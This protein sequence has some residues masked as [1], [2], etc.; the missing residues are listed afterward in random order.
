MF[1][2][3]INRDKIAQYPLSSR[4]DSK[5]LVIRRSSGSIEHRMFKDILDYLEK[6]DLVI[7]NNTKVLK[8]R[9]YGVK[10]NGKRVEI[11]L[12]K[13]L[14]SDTWSVMTRGIRKGR[15]FFS[16][17]GSAEIYREDDKKLAKFYGKK[18]DELMEII[19]EIPLP[20]YIK[21]KSEEFDQRRYQTIYA[22][23]NGSIAAP[24]AGLHFDKELLNNMEQ[25]GI[26]VKYITLHV[27]PGTFRPIRTT[28]IE[29]HKMDEEDYEIYRDT[30]NTYREVRA[31]KGRVIAVGTTVTRTLESAFF[32]G[33]IRWGRGST[34]L[35][36]YPGY[37]FRAVDGIITNFHLPK[38][39]PLLL[40][41]AFAGIELLKRAY[42]EAMELNYRFF[43]YGD[44][45]LII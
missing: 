38:S 31:S 27:G 17:G 30:A 2:Y 26:I 10:E 34:S 28:N 16:V 35:F 22:N 3:P 4:V 39:S 19:G 13:K 33:G 20:P 5:L 1:D 29:E 9:L 23:K 8:A 24:T 44:A 40:A 45:M 32:E 7:L 14:S 43:S 41:S 37:R 18:P 15:V 12:I 42:K 11:L 6:G 36:I 25:K 21:R